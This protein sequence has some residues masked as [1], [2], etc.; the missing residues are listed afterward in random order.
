[1][2]NRTSLQGRTKLS[3]K[4]LCIF[5]CVLCFP[6]NLFFPVSHGHFEAFRMQRESYTNLV[7]QTCSLP[8]QPGQR[9]LRMLAWEDDGDRVQSGNAMGWVKIRRRAGIL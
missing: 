2:A 1:M 3:A 7:C 9:L 8:F 4:E 5:T 6:P